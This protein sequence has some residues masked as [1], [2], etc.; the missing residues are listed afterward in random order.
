[1]FVR[2]LPFTA[3]LID[4]FFVINKTSRSLEQYRVFA[5]GPILIPTRDHVT[6]ALHGFPHNGYLLK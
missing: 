5:S 6:E 4:D 3:F 2:K 1:M